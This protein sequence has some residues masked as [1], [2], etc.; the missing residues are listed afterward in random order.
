MP[1]TGANWLTLML[2][3]GMQRLSEMYKD[4][5]FRKATGPDLFS[6]LQEI[7]RCAD[8]DSCRLSEPDT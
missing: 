5:D 4:A 8:L 7:C 3:E 2:D 1:G 6:M